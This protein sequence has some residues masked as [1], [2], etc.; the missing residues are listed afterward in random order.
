MSA[1]ATELFFILL[2]SFTTTCF[3][4]YGPSSDK[5]QQVFQFP[6]GE[7]QFTEP[8]YQLNIGSAI[9]FSYANP[10]HHIRDSPSY[11]ISTGHIIK[12]I[13]TSVLPD[14]IHI[15]GEHITQCLKCLYI[16]KSDSHI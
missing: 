6:L 13:N 1:I 4:P 3:G 11:Q 5:A 14:R 7:R 10:E 16:V 9:Y 12:K 2:Q 15:N 8:P